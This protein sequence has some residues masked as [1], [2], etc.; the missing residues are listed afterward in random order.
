MKKGLALLVLFN[1]ILLLASPAAA[2]ISA[3]NTKTKDE[4]TSVKYSGAEAI[5][6]GKGVL[7]RWRTEIEGEN[8]GFYIY[9]IS[10]DGTKLLYF[11]GSR[12]VLTD[13]RR[14]VLRKNIYV[15]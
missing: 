12:R 13:A 8:L 9:R 6:D 3:L 11:S 2:Q 7:I 15:F 10:A 14:P 5:T 4:K 1:F